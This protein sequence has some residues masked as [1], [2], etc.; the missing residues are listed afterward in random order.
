MPKKLRIMAK[1]SCGIP[2]Q[3]ARAADYW[4]ARRTIRNLPRSVGRDC[5]VMEGDRE[6]FKGVSVIL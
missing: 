4:E 5:V 6:A 1:S 3:V 2:Y